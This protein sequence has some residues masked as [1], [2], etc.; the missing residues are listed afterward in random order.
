MY[1]KFMKY[2]DITLVI[3]LSV[4]AI[5]LLYVAFIK[6]DALGLEVM[7]TGWAENFAIAKQ[8]Y[9]SEMY[10]SQQKDAIQQWLDSFWV[11]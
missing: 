1:M 11:K 2:L 3:A 5:L 9:N 6:T 8:Y 4:N 7:K 10:I